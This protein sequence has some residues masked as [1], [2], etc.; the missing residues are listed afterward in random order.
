[1]E[2]DLAIAVRLVGAMAIYVEHRI[3]AEVPQWADR[4]LAAAEQDPGVPGLAKV[5]GVAAAGARFAGNLDRGRNLASA[6]LA[7]VADPATEGY[8]C[9][10]LAEVALFS[11]QLEEA[12]ALS[13]HVLA[14]QPAVPVAPLIA[15]L[16]RLRC[17]TAEIRTP[18]SGVRRPCLP[19]RSASARR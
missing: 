16:G 14:L 2:H 17:F 5:Y 3:P 12:Q 18:P 6:G 7:I 9:Y 8:L 4:I 11:G 19:R 13:H 1:M 10:L 15:L